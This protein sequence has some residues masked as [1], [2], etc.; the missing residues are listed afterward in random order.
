VSDYNIYVNDVLAGTV[1]NVQSAQE[2][3]EFAPKVP[4][5]WSW[6][7]SAPQ[8]KNIRLRAERVAKM[9]K[10]DVRVFG[11][12]NGD[13]ILAFY[14][15]LMEAEPSDAPDYWH[16]FET[17]EACFN[18]FEDAWIK[19]D[20]PLYWDGNEREEYEWQMQDD[21]TLY[22]SFY[23]SERTIYVWD[24]KGNAEDAFYRLMTPVIESAKAQGT[25]VYN[26]KK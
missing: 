17:P 22:M 14:S 9:N 8:D 12:G 24:M 10:Y 20:D 25:I 23:Q 26:Y 1:R 7:K 11:L 15:N 19:G 18:A 2:A 21:D 3:L 6:M 13:L 5:I 16:T 4:T